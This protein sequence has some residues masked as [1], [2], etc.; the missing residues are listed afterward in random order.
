MST[1]TASDVGAHPIA[2]FATRLHAVLDDL[3]MVTAWSMTA[4]EQRGALVELARAES[5]LAEVRLR[6]LAAADSADVGAVTAASSTAAWVAHTTRQTRPA[7]HADLRLATRLDGP[8]EA[9]R[10]ALADGRLN[11]EQARVIVAAL[12][13]LSAG[14]P[15]ADRTRAE[16]HL[17]ALAADHDANALRILGRRVFEV[18]DPDAADAELG[19][20]LEAEEA[21]AARRTSLRIWDNRNGTHSG[22]FTISDLHAAMLTKAL[23]A[24]TNPRH[25]DRT[26]QGDPDRATQHERAG[27]PD[28]NAEQKALRQARPDQLGHAL[29]AL[30]ERLPAR[31]LPTTGGLSPTV[32]VLMELET[33]LTGIGAASLDTGHQISAAQ[34]RRLF[35]SSGVIPAVYARRLDG[36]TV[37]LDLGR[38]SRFHDRYQLIALT[39]RDRG[40]ITDGCDRPASWCQAH[41]DL[42]WADGGQTD[43]ATGR[44]LCPYHHGRAHSPGY[45][46]TRL[47]GGRI[48]FHR[49]T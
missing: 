2:R 1:T 27:R 14:V 40:C 35:C 46:T 13:H 48:R 37:P 12:D 31:R 18:I 30:L 3:S 20:R 26:G 38:R 29:C 33:L 15:T 16:A 43:V 28:H 34:A 42:P 41:H 49:R 23:Q 4:A 11:P 36:P 32:V 17:V 19:R 21:I 24:F 8:H 47:P 9:T 10:Q 22:R 5:R 45:D 25:R 44:L 39:I 6:V 7:A